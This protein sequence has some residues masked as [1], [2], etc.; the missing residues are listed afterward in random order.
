MSKMFHCYV[1]THSF[2]VILSFIFHLVWYFAEA[3]DSCTTRLG[4]CSPDT[5]TAT[6]LFLERKT[7]NGLDMYF[8]TRMMP[9]VPLLYSLIACDV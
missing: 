4:F 1:K 5:E 6:R 8:V 7:I 9:E 2:N 3:G